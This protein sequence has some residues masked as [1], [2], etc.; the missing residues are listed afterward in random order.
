MEPNY[1]TS[2][3]F[4]AAGL[5]CAIAI[6]WAPSFFKAEN[7]LGILHSAAV[8]LPAVIGAQALLVLGRFD[9]SSGAVAAMTGIVAGVTV[10]HTGSIG[11]SLLCAVASGV[12]LGLANGAVVARLRLNALVVTLATMGIAR[13]L[14]LGVSKGTVV[15]GFPDYIEWLTQGR[16]IGI[17]ALVF[18]AVAVCVLFEGLFRWAVLF[19]RFYAV[20]GN[21]LA[22]DCSGVY[23]QRLVVLGFV[24]SAVGASLTGLVQ[25]ARTLSASP[26]V[27]QDL[28]LEAISAC[29]VG[30]SSVR[31]GRGTM[32]GAACGL[33]VI[34]AT[35]NLVVLLGIGVYWRELVIGVLLLSALA[36]QTIAERRTRNA[37]SA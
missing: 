10:G 5:Y 7:V 22:A 32:V 26:L 28:P 2:V 3:V 35:R 19:R 13:S 20:G 11:L 18:G 12:L 14:A 4:I 16:I 9:L 23:S 1:R 34:A 36:V 33:V 17:P 37:D 24:V 29:V 27:F 15:T 21:E 31:G 6:V 25:C 30:G 8:L